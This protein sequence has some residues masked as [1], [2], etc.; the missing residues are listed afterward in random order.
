[1]SAVNRLDVWLNH[2]ILTSLNAGHWWEVKCRSKRLLA[3][4][5]HPE[6]LAARILTLL[7]MPERMAA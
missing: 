4:S 3:A 7:V 5:P 1:M 2:K 6:A